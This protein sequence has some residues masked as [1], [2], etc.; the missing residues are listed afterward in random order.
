[1]KK[2]IFLE[3]VKHNLK[4]F[5]WPAWFPYPTSWFRALILVPI[6]LPSTHLIVFGLTGI[7]I[8]VVESSPLLLL[9]SIL[10]GLILPATVLA[11]I[12]HFVWYMWHKRKSKG[13]LSKL[14]PSFISF[15]EALYTIFVLILSFSIIISIFSELAFLDCKVTENAEL[16]NVCTGRFTERAIKLILGSISTGDF[17]IKP[18]FIIWFFT[19]GYLY[20]FEHLIRKVLSYQLNKIFK[21]KDNTQNNYSLEVEFDVQDE[22]ETK[23]IKKRSKPQ[24]KVAVINQKYK[25]KRQ[26]FKIGKLILN[27]LLIVGSG[28]YFYTKFPEMKNN[29]SLYISSPNLSPT[30]KPDTGIFQKGLNKALNAGNLTKTAKSYKEWKKAINQWQAAIALMKTVPPSSPNYEIAQQQITEYKKSL[31]YAQESKKRSK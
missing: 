5:S 24:P 23:P 8:S 26:G 13:Y 11:F 12:Y 17:F 19:A 2:P 31:G 10:V 1:M 27:S 9:F 6:A 3:Q 28:I 4:E 18:W 21:T 16:L 20:Q 7:I 22:V 14:M 29:L 30:I 25:S 15:W